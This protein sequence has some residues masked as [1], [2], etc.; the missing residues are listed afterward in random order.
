MDQSAP[1][2]IRRW[3]GEATRPLSSP[4][5]PFRASNCVS[6]KIRCSAVP[7]ANVRPMGPSERALSDVEVVE[8]R[9]S[10]SRCDVGF[11]LAPRPAQSVRRRLGLEPYPC[12]VLERPGATPWCAALC[13][14]VDGRARVLLRESPRPPIH[15]R[16]HKTFVHPD[17]GVYLTIL[18]VV[19][20]LVEK[21]DPLVRKGSNAAR[22]RGARGGG[23]RGGSRDPA[24]PRRRDRASPGTTDEKL[25]FCSA[26]APL[27]ERDAPTGDGSVMEEW[28]RA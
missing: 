2:G 27:G 5:G 15:L 7:G 23:A 18:E 11:K 19:A 9:T 20:G 10:E 3:S 4:S 26:A 24:S 21:S 22:R 16:R 25:Y 8:D 1:P 17:P 13:E 14:F 12:D 6:T 28:S